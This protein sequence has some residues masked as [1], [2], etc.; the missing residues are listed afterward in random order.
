MTGYFGSATITF[1]TTTLTNA[2]TG[3]GEDIFIVKYDASGNVLWAKSAGGTQHD[4]GRSVSTDKSGNVFMTGYFGSATVTFG[5]TTLTNAGN[6]GS[7]DDIFIVKYDAS[8]NVQ[9]AKSAGGTAGDWGNSVSVDAGGNVFMTGDFQS[10]T[11][12]FG[13]T[14]L[15]NADTTAPAADIFIMK[16]DAAGNV[17]WA[18][19]AGGT[20]DD[21]GSSVS[22][23]AGGNVFMTGYF[24]SATITFGTTTLTNKDNS[25][26]S[27]DIFIVK[28]DASG[29][30]QWAKSAGGNSND[31]G[32][33]VSTD[34][35]G[36]VFVAGYFQSATITF[37]T[38]TLTNA[39]FSDIFIAKLSSTT[40][41]EEI[42][43]ENNFSLYPNPS[44]SS[45]T[46]QY[47][48]VL[49]RETNHG[50]ELTI[51]NVLGE[52]VYKDNWLPAQTQQTIN[53]AHL[54]KGL[55]IVRIGV[56]AERVVV[57]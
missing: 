51:Y 6:T 47:N 20:S 15:T 44:S 31:F 5:T 19:S 3:S 57:E 21:F 30:V 33:S 10:A 16:Y 12:T 23:D 4:Q 42:T 34:A 29:N 7:T 45:F 48:G 13:T 50:Q 18:K 17:L 27:G 52:Q 55:Y 11:I 39:G 35:G 46:I 26:N 1:G 32:Q 40:G 8:G 43:K 22:T 28:Y 37:G 56:R 14:T 25:G 2:D 54:P 53:V 38:T 49:G 24:Q 9:W 41:I 36:N